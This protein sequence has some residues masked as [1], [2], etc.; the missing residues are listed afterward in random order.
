M[1]NIKY[2][3][4]LVEYD[5]PQ[6]FVAQD[7]DGGKYIAVGVDYRGT[8]GYYLAG[9]DGNQLK[10][11][12]KG[13]LDLRSLFEESNK[14]KQ[15]L[16]I[17]PDLDRPLNVSSL[18][19]TPSVCGFL[20]DRGFFLD[21]EPNYTFKLSQWLKKWNRK[22]KKELVAEYGT[23]DLPL[24]LNGIKIECY[25]LNDHPTVPTRVFTQ[26]GFFGALGLDRS[27]ERRKKGGGEVLIFTPEKWLRPC[28]SEELEVAAK[29]PI[30]FRGPDGIVFGYNV[31]I[32]I[33]FM[34]AILEAHCAGYTKYGEDQVNLVI[35]RVFQ[36]QDYLMGGLLDV[37]GVNSHVFQMQEHLM[38]GLLTADVDKVTG[39]QNRQTK[40]VAAFQ[41]P[42]LFS[43]EKSLVA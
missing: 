7:G 28:F 35:S 26:C 8:D 31:S 5:G 33:Q 30:R 41:Q 4:T 24:V 21:G 38:G 27:T 20:P 15:Y 11:F 25:V 32:M 43:S 22:S 39:F 37:R 34:F 2:I 9:V 23:K 19:D 1:K 17:E 13:K 6:V 40:D 18:P 36:M 14:D 12:C 29:R 3:E 42:N 16:V 10:R